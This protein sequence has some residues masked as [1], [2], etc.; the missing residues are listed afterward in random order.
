MLH[1]TLTDNHMSLFCLID[2]EATSN[3][4]SF[5]IPSNDTVD[6][7]KGAIKAKKINDFSDVDADKLTLWRVSISDD[8]DSDL[9]IPFDS[10]LDKKKLKATTKLSRVF[11]GELPEDT[12]HVIA[13]RPPPI[14]APVPARVST[15]LSGYLS[16]Q[17]RPGTPL[18]GDLHADIKRITDRFFASGPIVD[19]LGAFVRGEKKLP[20][21]ERSVRGLPKAWRRTFGHPPDTRPSL[22]FLDLPD[23][24]TPDPENRNLAAGSILNM[25]KENNRPSSPCSA[26]LGVARRAQ[27]L[28][29][30]PST[31]DSTS[32][33]LMTTGDLT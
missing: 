32:T 33:L 15:P 8:D 30:C 11:I 18:S 16:D 28:S 14:H 25:V 2:G 9:P 17:S 31:G 21:T 19:F 7:L 27:R 5:K 20:V 4:F 10:V 26:S 29:S 12:I 6:D 1:S 23:P 3:A 24:S 22:L 13:Q